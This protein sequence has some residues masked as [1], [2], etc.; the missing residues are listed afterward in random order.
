MN[1][2][3][4]LRS[5]FDLRLEHEFQTVMGRQRYAPPQS[6]SNAY[7]LGRNTVPGAMAAHGTRVTREAP[8]VLLLEGISVACSY[9]RRRRQVVL[10]PWRQ[11]VP[12][13]GFE[14]GVRLA[15]VPVVGNQFGGRAGCPNAIQPEPFTVSTS[16]I[17]PSMGNWQAACALRGDKPGFYPGRHGL[18]GYLSFG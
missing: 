13:A 9:R 3:A 2:A 1:A 14:S 11:R 4:P 18:C 17:R 8:V 5:D 7:G 6:L 16:F 10:K 15:P 12:K